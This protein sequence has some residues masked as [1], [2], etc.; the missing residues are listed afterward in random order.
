M[1]KCTYNFKHN[2]VTYGNYDSKSTVYIN[3]NLL[4]SAYVLTTDC[5]RKALCKY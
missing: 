3:I 4:P 1:F 5:R 2:T